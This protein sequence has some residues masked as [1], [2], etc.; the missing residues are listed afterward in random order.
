MVLSSAEE[1]VRKEVEQEAVN[2]TSPA[3]LV[4]PNQPPA[5]L[6]TNSNDANITVLGRKRQ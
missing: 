3:I 2:S 5:V 1:G 4:L 6:L